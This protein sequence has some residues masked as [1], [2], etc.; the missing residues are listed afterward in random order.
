MSG[1]QGAQVQTWGS[2]T[3]YSQGTQGQA[4]TPTSSW[5]QQAH[6]WA[7]MPPVGSRMN[8]AIRKAGTAY[9]FIDMDDHIG[10]ALFV[11]PPSCGG[12]IPP[13][14]TRVSYTVIS[15]GTTGKLRAEDVYPEGQGPPDASAPAPMASITNG[16][17]S[18][19]GTS[20]PPMEQ[21]MPHAD[22]NQYEVPA[23]TIPQNST[24]SGVIQSISDQYGFITQDIGGETM[25][26]MP[27]ACQAFG[28]VIPPVGTRVT[29]TVI[30]DAQTGKP[31]AE[32]VQPDGAP[33]G[34]YG[35]YGVGAVGTAAYD[36]SA[37]VNGGYSPQG[38]AT[39]VN[40]PGPY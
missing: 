11:L 8:G 6:Y 17:G 16:T 29:Y 2:G 9:G 12:I 31:R 35:E 5:G 32:N 33:A 23:Y 18:E 20:A 30:A 24:Y 10:E 38:Q 34:G 36:A 1:G 25:F 13:A 27:V 3:S 4:F 22:H 19:Y 26:V 15:D 39:Q 28:G 37:P 14:G 21:G 7:R 40:R